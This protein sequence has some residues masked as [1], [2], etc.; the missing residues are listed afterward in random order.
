MIALRVLKED[1][2]QKFKEYIGSVRNN[3]QT[4]CPDLNIEPYSYEFQ[5][6]V[7]IDE[8][9]SFATRMEMGRY[10]FECFDNAG[11]QRSDVVGKGKEDL[12][13]WLAYIWFE[14]ITNGRQKIQEISKY[15]CSSD[16]TDYYRH[17]VAGPYYVY[18]IHREHNSRLILHNPPDT[19]GDYFEQVASRQYIISHPNLVETA[20]MLYWDSSRNFPK[21]GA[22]SRERPGNLR[23]FV[24]IIGQLE[25]TYDIYTMS[26]GEILNLLPAEF[27]QWKGSR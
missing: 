2:I 23:R 10:L 4:P 13:T 22:Q 18:S 12:W 6:R 25:L 14:Q 15:V 19:P 20:H 16:Y 7:E 17:L 21:R 5:P 11:I 3:Q 8:S 26:P 9:R 1:G 24:K 27:G